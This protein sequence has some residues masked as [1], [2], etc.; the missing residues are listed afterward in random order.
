M[1]S[2]LILCRVFLE[3]CSGVVVFNEGDVQKFEVH[4]WCGG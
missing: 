3:E 1:V 4:I 2:V